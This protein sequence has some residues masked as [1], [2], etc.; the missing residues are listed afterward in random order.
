MT[1]GRVQLHDSSQTP[2]MEPGVTQQGQRKRALV[3]HL[4]GGGTWHKAWHLGSSQN[5]L[6]I[7]NATR[8]Y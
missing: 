4:E 6:L 5:L 7:M 1:E 8:V 3:Q 2:Q